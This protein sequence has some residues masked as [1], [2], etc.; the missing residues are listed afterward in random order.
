LR[1]CCRIWKSGSE[2]SRASRRSRARFYRQHSYHKLSAALDE[3]GGIAAWRHRL[4]STPIRAVFDTAEQLKDAKHVASQ[5]LPG[6]TPYRIANYRVE[7]APAQSVVPR[8][9]WRS[10]SSS[11]NTFA[12]ECF[13]DE[14][15]HAAG[16][17]ACAFRLK[18]LRPEMGRLRAAIELAAEKSGWGKALAA[19]E[20]R[21]IACYA[22][23][24]SCIAHVAEVSVADSGAVRVK[25]I[26]SAVDCGTAVNPDGVRA[27]LEGSVNFALTPV[28]TGEIT[29]EMGAVK[30]SN[31]HDYKVLRI[32]QA[33]AIEVYLAPSDLPPGGMGSQEFRRWLL[34][35]PTQYLP[36]QASAYAG[37][38]WDRS[39]VKAISHH[40]NKWNR[41]AMQA[42][43]IIIGSPG[44]IP[45]RS[46]E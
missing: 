29:V 32:D 46:A 45:R 17:D 13:M 28:L 16:S 12:V 4:V 39:Q 18:L 26:I 7:Y 22:G 34:P 38:P 33:P 25:R 9:W 43:K 21:G 20:G 14:L 27:M 36:Q 11:F 30:E 8:A 44:I 41:T 6:E 24:G 37:C 40:R 2:R 15:A 23:F 35:W 3:Q 1:Q 10:V 42:E 31:F 19:G 5:D